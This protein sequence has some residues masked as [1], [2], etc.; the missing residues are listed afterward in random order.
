MFIQSAPVGTSL[1]TGLVLLAGPCS[2]TSDPGQTTHQ[3][4]TSIIRHA[5]QS[6]ALFGEKE[7]LISEI[8]ELAEKCSVENWDGYD[9]AP[10]SA[11]SFQTACDFIRLLPDGIPLPEISSEPDGSISLDWMPSRY[12]TFSLSIGTSD[13]FAYAW[14]DGSDRGH[15]VA[16]FDFQTIPERILQGIKLFA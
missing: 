8:F 12:R 11:Q 3:A 13:Q 15:A 1:V 16:R 2:A 9:S 7:D 5:E 4:R 6:R 10:I 14:V